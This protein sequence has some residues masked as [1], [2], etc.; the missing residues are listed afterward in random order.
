M[1]PLLCRNRQER[2]CNPPFSTRKSMLK[3]CAASGKQLIAVQ[4]HSLWGGLPCGPW[5]GYPRN[6]T[7]RRAWSVTRASDQSSCVASKG[8]KPFKLGRSSLHGPRRNWARTERTWV[9]AERL[10]VAAVAL[11]SP[12]RDHCSKSSAIFNE[13]WFDA[14]GLCL[15]LADPAYPAAQSDRHNNYCWICHGLNPRIARYRATCTFG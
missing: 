4:V 9:D 5:Q 8:A 13:R 11:E 15:G 7:S 6:H 1:M 10:P 2:R 14:G 12:C 3:S